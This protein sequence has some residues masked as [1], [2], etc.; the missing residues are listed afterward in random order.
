MRVGLVSYRLGEVDGVSVEAAKW[1]AS[2]RR[3]GCEVIT[4]AGEGS[5]DVLIPG[6]R[7]DRSGPMEVQLLDDFLDRC[8][9]IVV[10]NVLS[11]P[12]NMAASTALA[13]RLKGRPAILH[14]H[15]TARQRSL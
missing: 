10:E 6:F 12:L 11:L 7:H 15:D 8:D 1:A 13:Q 2:L 14:H 4:A 5:A 9:V 3:I